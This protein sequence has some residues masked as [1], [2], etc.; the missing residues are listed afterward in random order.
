MS[1]SQISHIESTKETFLKQLV[2]IEE[3]FNELNNMY[4]Y[5]TPIQERV[6][7]FLSL[8]ISELESYIK[9][10]GWNGPLSKVFIGTKVTVQFKDESETE[11]ED[12]IISLPDQSDP[13]ANRISFLSP[14]GRQLLLKNVGDEISLVVPNGTVS[15]SIKRIS[16][17]GN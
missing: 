8:Y 16:F 7:N 1:L 12:Y 4:L 17:S 3:N 14:V 6:K 11:T 9:D 10:G 15:L 5:S 2:F 13:D